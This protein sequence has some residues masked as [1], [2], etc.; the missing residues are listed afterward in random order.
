MKGNSKSRSL[1]HPKENR[2]KHFTLDSCMVKEKGLSHKDYISLFGLLF[3]KLKVEL[4]EIIS[5]LRFEKS[6]HYSNMTGSSNV[7]VLLI[8]I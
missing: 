2:L 8:L 3:G 4:K 6:R 5:K 1:S 7:V